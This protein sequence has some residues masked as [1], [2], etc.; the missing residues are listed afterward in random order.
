M[1]AIPR[2]TPNSRIINLSSGAGSLTLASDPNSPM[3][4]GFDA[5]YAASKTALNGQTLAMAIEPGAYGIRSTQWHGYTK[6][7][8]NGFTGTETLEE[9]AAEAVRVALL[10]SEGGHAMERAG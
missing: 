4:A 2:E 9:D 8:T 1:A 7:K 10:G 6:T 3:R 5:A